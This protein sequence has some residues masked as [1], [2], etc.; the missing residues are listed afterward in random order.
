MDSARYATSGSKEAVYYWSHSRQEQGLK[1]TVNLL[2]AKCPTAHGVIAWLQYSSPGTSTALSTLLSDARLLERWW[3]DSVWCRHL[4]MPAAACLLYSLSI[5]NFTPVPQI[6]IPTQG[7]E[8][9][10][11]WHSG[12]DTG[13]NLTL[14]HQVF[15]MS[16]THAVPFSGRTHYLCPPGL[17]AK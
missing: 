1:Q 15:Y 16:S 8:G 11:Y 6:S 5:C 7:N 2:K 14:E 4:C 12:C 3:G 9:Y 10:K 17:H 13:E